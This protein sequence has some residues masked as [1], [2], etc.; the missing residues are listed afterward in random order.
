MADVSYPELFK[1]VTELSERAMEAQDRV[2]QAR[3]QSHAEVQSRIATLRATEERRRQQAIARGDAANKEPGSS[4][5]RLRAHVDEQ[6]KKMHTEMDQNQGRHY[7]NV[8]QR[9]ADWAETSAFDA[10]DF[11]YDAVVEAEAAVLDAIDLRAAAEEKTAGQLG[12]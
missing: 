9:R 4:W 8:A 10:V 11:A 7:A 5:A 6:L 12:S 2:N 1:R 3:A